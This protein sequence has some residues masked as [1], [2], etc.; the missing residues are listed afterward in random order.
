M[1][2]PVVYNWTA[3]NTTDVCKVQTLAG[4]GN[5]I[6]NGN[7]TTTSTGMG[8]SA[9]AS[10]PTGYIVTFVGCSRTVSVTSTSDNSTVNVT[11]QGFY[12]GVSQIE[13]R[14]GPNNTTVYTTKL[15]DSVTSVSTDAATIGAGLSVGSGT[16]GN[17]QW[18]LYNYHTGVPNLSVEVDVTGTINYSFQQTLYDVSIVEPVAPFQGIIGPKPNDVN[19]FTEYMLNTTD[20]QFSFIN[21]PIRYANIIINSATDGAL[22]AIFLQQGI[23]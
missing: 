19:A 9:S 10:S 12:R 21:Y 7:L 13:T 20:G 3:A 2:R 5:L 18:F 16:T 14:T 6:I 17:T 11:I 15:F 23:T 22:I 1:A 4:A 8:I